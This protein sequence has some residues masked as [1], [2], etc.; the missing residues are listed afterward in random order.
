M[1][2]DT[3]VH[4]LMVNLKEMEHILGAMVPSIKDNLRMD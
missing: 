1:E 2:I 4:I 3:R